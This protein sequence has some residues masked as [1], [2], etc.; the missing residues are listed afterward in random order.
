MNYSYAGDAPK[1]ASQ[2]TIP[3]TV[4]LIGNGW[5]DPVHKL[6][7]YQSGCCGYST[8]KRR[9][10]DAIYWTSGWD[11]ICR[12]GDNKSVNRHSSSRVLSEGWWIGCKQQRDRVSLAPDDFPVSVPANSPLAL[13]SLTQM[14]ISYWS[15]SPTISWV[16]NC[17]RRFDIHRFHL[18]HCFFLPHVTLG[19]QFFNFLTT[20]PIW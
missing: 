19:L 4:R 16:G 8:V 7:K 17:R 13:L 5:G 1:A 3:G 9:I 12:K 2:V 14:G 20:A 18:S 11:M 15:S 10:Q 6:D